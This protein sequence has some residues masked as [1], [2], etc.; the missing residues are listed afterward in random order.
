M[1]EFDRRLSRRAALRSAAGA[2]LAAGGLG[3]GALTAATPA[4]AAGGF[5]SVRQFQGTWRGA[6]DGRNATFTIR[7][8]PQPPSNFSTLLFT[9]NDLDRHETYTGHQE[10]VSQ[11]TFDL[12][13]IVLSNG[14]ATKEWATLKLH[15]WN[16]DYISGISRWNG[17]IYPN[18]WT[19]SNVAPAYAPGPGFSDYTSFLNNGGRADYIG[20]HDG[21]N[22]RLSVW[23]SSELA[24]PR[25]P[26]SSKPTIRFEMWDLD[27]NEGYY[28]EIWEEILQAA[29]PGDIVNPF[30]HP[31]VYDPN[32]TEGY[33]M[34]L[35]QL[36]ALGMDLP[37]LAWHGWNRNYVSGYTIWSDGNRVSRT[38]GIQFQRV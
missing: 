18:C 19:R 8:L 9:F 36:P 10:N 37:Y 2:A 21:R 27:R 35:R 3:A 34:P 11:D 4:A 16:T 28:Y 14:S 26:F 20:H 38:Y 13:N 7:V 33:W 23:R 17:G 1:K 22:A 29:R 5:Q 31:P 6:Q 12:R 25:D 24:N 32:D 30:N 15:T